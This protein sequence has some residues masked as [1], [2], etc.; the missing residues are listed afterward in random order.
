MRR[1]ALTL[2][3]TNISQEAMLCLSRRSCV[4]FIAWLQAPLSLG[5]SVG[6]SASAGA[7]QLHRAARLMPARRWSLLL[8]GPALLNHSRVWHGPDSALLLLKPAGGWS[9]KLAGFALLMHSRPCSG[10]LHA[11]LA[12]PVTGPAGQAQLLDGIDPI[13]LA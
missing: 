4:Q 10:Q 8:L 12:I 7:P 3:M 1:C 9:C 5:F 6:Q 2:Q 11:F 13:L